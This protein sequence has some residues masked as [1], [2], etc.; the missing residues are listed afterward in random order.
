METENVLSI[1]T[2][3][4]MF[5]L[6]TWTIFST[7]STTLIM[8]RSHHH[9]SERVT[10]ERGAGLWNINKIPNPPFDIQKS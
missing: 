8:V 9:Q 5:L 10:I 3:N 1:H 6:E 4:G 7:W 2:V